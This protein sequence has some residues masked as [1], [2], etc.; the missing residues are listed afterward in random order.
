[1]DT[2]PPSIT[3]RAKGGLSAI[4]I[5]IMVPSLG[6]YVWGLRSMGRNFNGSSGFGVRL[7]QEHALS[8]TGPYAYLRH[9]MC[10]AVILACWGGLLLY[11]TWSMLVLAFMM[12]GL[13]YRVRTEQQALGLAFGDE[14]EQYKSNVPGWLP[15]LKRKN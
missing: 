6:V 8:T 4:G 7:Y 11:R 1:M 15:M 5:M 14:W 12:L 3:E 13:L 9:P 10:L 2:H